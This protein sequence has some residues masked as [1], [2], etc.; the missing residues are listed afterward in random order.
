MQVIKGQVPSKSNGYKVIK[1]NGKGT[2]CKSN[3]LKYYEYIFFIQC[4]KYRNKNIDVPFEIDVKVYYSSQRSD[5]D[6]A[7]KIILDCLQNVKAIKNDNKCV[8]ITAYKLIDKLNPR[9]EFTI[10]PLCTNSK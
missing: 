7:L 4:D 9:I 2:L 5:L 6:N 1:V 10:N 8:K 3:K